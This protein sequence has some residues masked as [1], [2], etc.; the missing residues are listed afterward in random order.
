MTSLFRFRP[1]ACTARRFTSAS[2]PISLKKYIEDVKPLLKPPVANRMIYNEQLQVMVVGGP[3]QRKVLYMC[4]YIFIVIF[5]DRI[6]ILMKERCFQSTLLILSPHVFFVQ[7]IFYQVD[8]AMDVMI[9]EHGEHKTIHIPQ[10]HM[11][12]LP[13]RIPHSPQRFLPACF[14]CI[15]RIVMEI[16]QFPHICRYANTIGIVVERLRK[17]HEAD[18]L[19]YFVPGTTDVL[20]E[21]YFHCKDL[22]SELV[23]VIQRYSIRL[24]WTHICDII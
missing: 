24:I 15:G 1:L 17:P 5:S 7:E 22:G 21:E 19:R 23:P 18:G 10:G 6:T 11:F 13:G 20:Y 12:I 4:V 14:M 3:N 16:T 2:P 9:L 8:G